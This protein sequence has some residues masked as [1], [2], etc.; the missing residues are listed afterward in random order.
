MTCGCRSSP[1]ARPTVSGAL[2]GALD[3]RPVAALR[4]HLSEGD[5]HPRRPPPHRAPRRPL[6]DHEPLRGLLLRGRQPLPSQPARPAAR[7]GRGRDGRWVGG[8]EAEG[9]PSDCQRRHPELT[10]HYPSPTRGAIRPAAVAE[11]GCARRLST[12]S[13]TNVASQIRTPRRRRRAAGASGALA[14]ESGEPRSSSAPSR[15]RAR[16][17]TPRSFSS[18]R[19]PPTTASRARASSPSHEDSRGFMWFGTT[20]GLNRYDGY[21]FAVYRHRD[22]DSTSLAASNALT[23]YEDAQKTLWVGTPAGLSRYDRE[24][25]AFE[26]YRVVGDRHAPGQRHP[27]GAGDALARHRARASTSSIARRARRRPTAG[28]S[29][30]SRSRVCSRTAASICGSPAGARARSSSIR[31]PDR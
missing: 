13:H 17:R 27:R 1:R 22:G 24:R 19:S 18:G 28:S 15:S 9:E 5:G 23:I 29:P 8:S 16:A 21:G 4:A 7:R 14:R 6:A 26:N 20:K 11:P 25:D 10:T 30:R 2:V 3:P 12:P 31:A